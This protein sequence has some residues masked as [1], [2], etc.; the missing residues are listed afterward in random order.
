[1]TYEIDL[2]AGNFYFHCD[3]HPGMSGDVT[4]K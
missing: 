2:K 1:V 4:V 3:I